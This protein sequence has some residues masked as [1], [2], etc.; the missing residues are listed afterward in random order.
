MGTAFPKNIETISDGESFIIRRKWFTNSAFGYLFFSILWNGFM[1]VW[2]GL[3]ISD[4]AWLMAAFGSI[5]AGVGLYLIYFTAAKFLNVTDI[6][7]TPERLTTR[8]TP[9][10]WI[11]LKE[12]PIHHITRL[13]TKEHVQSGEDSDTITYRV[14]LLAEGNKE[15]KLITGLDEYD[16]AKFIKTAIC[17]ILG[18]EE[19]DLGGI[20][21]NPRSR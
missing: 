16:Q 18:L 7:I 17:G 6:T 1:V 8:H 10:P 13:Y 2:M 11:G 9:L 20:I 21:E 3:A 19:V 14:M 4:G 5:H 15:Y 12:I